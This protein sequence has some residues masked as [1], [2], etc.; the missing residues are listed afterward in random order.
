MEPARRK[1]PAGTHLNSIRRHR[2]CDSL[3]Y[4][5]SKVIL[6][7]QKINRHPPGLIPLHTDKARLLHHFIHRFELPVHGE[8]EAEQ[9]AWIS[10]LAQDVVGVQVK[11]GQ[12]PAFQE[13]DEQQ[14]QST[15]DPGPHDYNPVQNFEAL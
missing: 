15:G 7:A 6:T 5:F 2:L 13:K 1:I 9:A 14:G 10:V 11:G 8:R 4:L 12:P 3:H